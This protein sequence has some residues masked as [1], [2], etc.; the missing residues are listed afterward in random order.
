LQSVNAVVNG[1]RTMLAGDLNSSEMQAL[2]VRDPNAWVVA[3]EDYNAR[4]RQVDD[5]LNHLHTEYERHRGEV[6]TTQKQTASATVEQ[7]IERLREFIPDWSEGKNG[8]PSGA[9]RLGDY[10]RKSGFQDAEFTDIA[11]HRML[12]IADKARRYDELVARRS[13][14]PE[15][16]AKPVPKRVV[17]GQSKTASNGQRSDRQDRSE[18]KQAR[19]R[20]AKTGNMRDAGDALNAMFRRDAKRGDKRRPR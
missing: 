20:L 11:D 17:P 2:R 3:R 19:E 16:K 14:E 18:F 13:T 10:L 9:Q 6:E 4:I 8:K 1:V 12:A 7:E 15:R 5:V